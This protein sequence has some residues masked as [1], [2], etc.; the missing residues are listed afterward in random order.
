MVAGGRG[1]VDGRVDGLAGLRDV[2]PQM[3]LSGEVARPLRHGQDC[4]SQTTA[5]VMVHA[6]AYNTWA[7]QVQH[8]VPLAS[9]AV[10]SCHVAALASL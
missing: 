6:C 5:R 10:I 4:K 8:L 3:K 9:E 7:L 1:R 2:L